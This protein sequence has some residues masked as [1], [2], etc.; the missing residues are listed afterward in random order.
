MADS[1]QF[2]PDKD[3]IKQFQIQPNIG[4]HLALQLVT[5]GIT[6]ID[7]LRDI[8]SETAF[9]R[10]NE[11]D[12]SQCINSLYALEGAIQG[13]RWHSLEKTRKRELLDFF[14][15]VKGGVEK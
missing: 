8:G 13:I 3:A 10:L 2:S 14:N 7:Q 4:N 12:N 15:Q 5:A 11:M 6:S 1:K 9:I